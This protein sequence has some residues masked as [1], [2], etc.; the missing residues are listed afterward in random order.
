[1]SEAAAPSSFKKKI[2]KSVGLSSMEFAVKFG[3]RLVSTVILTR[4]L[5]PDIYGVFAVVLVYQYMLEMFSDIGLRSFVITKE[6]EVDDDLVQ[7]CW[8]ASILRGLFILGV[9]GLIALL[10]AYL[11]SRGVFADDSAYSAEVLPWAIFAL[12]ATSL[13]FS[14]QSISLYVYE[15][16]MAFTHVSLSIILSSVLGLIVTIT[17]AWLNPTVWALVIGTAAQFGF[18]V[19]YSFLAFKGPPMRLRWHGPSGRLIINRGKWLIGHSSLTAMANSADRVLLGILMDS[20]TFGLY[21][22]AVQIRDF[23]HSF[24]TMVHARMGLQ[25]FTH[26]LQ[27]PPDVFRRN[28]YKYRMVFDAL[29]GLGAGT[30][31]MIAQPLVDLVFDDR[32]AGVAPILQILALAFVLVGPVLLRSAFSAERKFRQ[33]MN[34]SIVTTITLWVGL[35][36]TIFFFD[37]LTGALLVIALHTL[38][39]AIILTIA[40][41]RRDWV[42][43]W[44]EMMTV[45]FLAL[46][47]ALGWG[48]LEIWER[49][50]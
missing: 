49:L 47:L 5:A 26:I 23:C 18:Q 40:G 36:V 30:L 43:L 12:G 20:T 13:L 32:Y 31:I 34:L 50:A 10:I 29:A 25:V 44:G 27:A 4:M 37:T 42:R 19:I 3:L 6:G 8:T 14:F 11:Q 16:N 35:A 39:E 15:R 38:P 17:A 7:T 48:L 1:M 28:Y 2:A 24:L 33:M 9:S 46:G 21:Y 45:V 22:I 41:Y